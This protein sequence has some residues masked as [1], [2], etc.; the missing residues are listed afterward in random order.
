MLR[1]T[2]N[3]D[4][5]RSYYQVLNISPDE[6]DPKVI[7]EAALRCYGAVRPYQMTRESESTLRMNEI[8]RALSTLLDPVRRRDYDLSLAKLPSPALSERR[9]PGQRDPAALPR[10]KSAPTPEKK[11]AAMLARGWR[12]TCDVK[13]VFRRRAR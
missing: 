7:E 1:L 9:P 11:H 4:P 8:A 12:G 5:Q 13:L 6:Q 3:V 2:Q 10:S